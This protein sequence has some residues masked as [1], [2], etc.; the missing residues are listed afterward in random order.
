[1]SALA[2]YF[3]VL[4]KRVGGYDRT[5]TSLTN[6]L[7][8]QGMEINYADDIDS[9]PSDYTKIENIDEV[10]VVYTPAIPRTSVQLRYF[11]MNGFML[12]KRSQVLGEISKN[13]KTLAIGGSHGKTTIS[14]MIAEI[15]R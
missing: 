6:A 10:L 9:I 5:E 7:A 15:F 4:G 11:Q 13:Y 2:R 14:A 8:T 12:F 1:M 3:N